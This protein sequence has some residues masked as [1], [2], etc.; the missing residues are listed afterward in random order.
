MR[1]LKGLLCFWVIIFV[2]VFLL[3]TTHSSSETRVNQILTRVQNAL[4]E[5]DFIIPTEHLKPVLPMRKFYQVQE[6]TLNRFTIETRQLFRKQNTI[7][8]VMTDGFHI[9]MPPNAKWYQHKIVFGD[10]IA[11]D[12]KLAHKERAEAASLSKK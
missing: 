2:S 6:N 10:D 4:H 1:F 8:S 3:Y 5:K 11:A 12:I 9:V 7:G